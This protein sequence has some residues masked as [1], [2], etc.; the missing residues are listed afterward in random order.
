LLALRPNNSV[1]LPFGGIVYQLM[2][3][4]I[5]VLLMA[6]A[7]AQ[8]VSAAPQT[9]DFKD[10][11]NGNN[12][13]FKLVAPKETIQGNAN[14][15]SGTV[16]FDP[17]QP[18]AIKGKIIVAAKSLTVPNGMMKQHLHSGTWIDVAKFPEITFE[19]K[20]LKNVKTEGEKISADVVGNFTL[21]GV[22]K[23]I[24]APATL[25]YLKDKLGDRFPG[26]K[27]DLLVIRSTFNVQR[28]DFNVNAHNN[29][30]KVAD[31]IELTLGAAGA[32]EK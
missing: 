30:D 12:V 9:F 21:K 26:K 8:T 28:S 29:E 1:H 24:T 22:S 4:R 13:A 5:L 10:P 31:K 27:G 6:A 7:L 18:A 3:P 25:T 23:E 20:E 15:I 14:G 16:T 17:E 19:V 32:A 2:K 11:K